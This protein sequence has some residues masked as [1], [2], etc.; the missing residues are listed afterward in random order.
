MLAALNIVV[1]LI[2][3]ALGANFIWTSNDMASDEQEVL[4]TS[5]R[6]TPVR[7]WSHRLGGAFLILV[8]VSICVNPLF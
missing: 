8:G 1:G 2:V 3:M 7:S 4:R 5:R 6:W